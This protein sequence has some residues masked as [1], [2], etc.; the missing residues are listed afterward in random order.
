M[1]AVLDEVCPDTVGNW[2]LGKHCLSSR[3]P[4]PAGMKSS[5]DPGTPC[6][7]GGVRRDSFR[8]LL[9]PVRNAPKERAAKRETAVRGGGDK[10]RGRRS[11]WEPL[12]PGHSRAAAAGGRRCPRGRD[13]AGTKQREFTAS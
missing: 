1:T 6:R 2:C 13:A 4:V 12:S 10:P 8:T 11:G 5:P 7:A 3:E 9:R